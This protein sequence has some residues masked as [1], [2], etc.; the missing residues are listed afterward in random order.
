MLSVKRPFTLPHN[1]FGTAICLDPVNVHF[2]G[3]DHKIDMSQAEVATSG[4][5][6]VITQ[7]FAV[8]ERKPVGAS[9]GQVAGGVFINQR[10]VEQVSASGDRR[11]VGARR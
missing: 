5:E 9:K 11:T 6:F 10:I 1:R 4:L 8:S 7:A 3:A 2:S